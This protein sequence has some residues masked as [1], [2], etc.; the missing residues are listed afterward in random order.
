MTVKTNIFL[1]DDTV[2][3]V[4]K[5]NDYTVVSIQNPTGIGSEALLFFNSSETLERFLTVI[6]A[7]KDVEEV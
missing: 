3:K 6:N 5:A 2:M 4:S 7:N 1:R